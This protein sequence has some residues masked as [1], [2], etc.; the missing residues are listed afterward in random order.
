MGVLGAWNANLGSIHFMTYAQRIHLVRGKQGAQR[1][2]GTS[3]GRFWGKNKSIITYNVHRGDPSTLANL[4]QPRPKLYNLLS[5][6]KKIPNAT[7]LVRRFFFRDQPLEGE[8]ARK[9]YCLRQG[10]SKRGE[11]Q[12]FLSC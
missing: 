5:K 12:P 4:V 1:D 6:R 2:K 10:T 8:G 7:I 11:G 9:F 3:I